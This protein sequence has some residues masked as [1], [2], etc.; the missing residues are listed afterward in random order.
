MQPEVLEQLIAYISTEPKEEDEED[1]A[2]QEK[3]K[4]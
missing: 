2:E 4:R 3:Q 1:E